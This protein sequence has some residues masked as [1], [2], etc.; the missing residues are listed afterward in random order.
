MIF[1]EDREL[2]KADIE[3]F[4]SIIDGTTEWPSADRDVIDVLS[5]DFGYGWE[6]DINICRGIPTPYVDAILFHEGHEV[7]LW[8]ISECVTGEWAVVLGEDIN[9]AFRLQVF[10]KLERDES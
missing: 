1:T 5:V 9:R 8:E 2:P 7:Y 3:R 10:A 6:V 4:Q